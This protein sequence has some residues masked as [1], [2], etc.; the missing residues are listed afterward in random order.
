MAAED[1]DRMNDVPEPIFD[2]SDDLYGSTC[3]NCNGDGWLHGCCDDMCRVCNEA[4]DCDSPRKCMNCNPQ[5][6]IY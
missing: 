5:G 4:E 6:D 2:D 1:Q 3:F